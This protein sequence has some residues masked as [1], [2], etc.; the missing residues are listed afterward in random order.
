[1]SFLPMGKH[2]AV[3]A[4]RCEQGKTIAGKGLQ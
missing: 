3:R 2:S 1:M 4:L